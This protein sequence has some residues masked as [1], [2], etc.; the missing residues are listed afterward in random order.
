[1]CGYYYKKHSELKNYKQRNLLHYHVKKK[2]VILIHKERNLLYYYV[3]K[4]IIEK[5]PLLFPPHSHELFL[6]SINQ[7]REYI[8]YLV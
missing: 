6:I 2:S 3:K 1:M 5:N 4:L 7:K 8:I